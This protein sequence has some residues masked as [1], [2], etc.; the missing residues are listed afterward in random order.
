MVV[1]SDGLILGVVG[2]IDQH[3]AATGAHLEAVAEGGVEG[4][5]P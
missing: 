5:L 2:L 3:Y 1:W 4:A